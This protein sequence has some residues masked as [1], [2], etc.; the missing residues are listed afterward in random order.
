MTRAEY[1][2]NPCRTS[3]IPFWKTKEILVPDT[4][5]IIHDAEFDESFLQDYHDEP[6]FRIMHTLHDLTD[7]TLPN[8]FSFSSASVEEF[9]EHINRCYSTLH[10]SPEELHSY[11]MRSVYCPDLWIT[12][13]DNQSGI[14]AASGIAELDS[15]IGEGVLEWIQVS[16]DC[17]R[18]GLGG[19]LVQ[20]LLHRM[21]ERA[22]FVTV[23]GQCNNPANPEALYR[24]CGF[25][26]SDVWHIMKKR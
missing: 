2:T 25:V 4:M 14:I 24:K 16:K 6:Y 8:T 19:C 22:S 3:S 9:S 1:L 21:K 12:I 15:E 5:K 17:R 18:N 26:G 23:S 11:T 7:F 10:I 20:E 13:K